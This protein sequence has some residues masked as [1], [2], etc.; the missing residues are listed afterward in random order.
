MKNKNSMFYWWPKVKNLPIPQPRTVM[1]RFKGDFTL[2]ILDG[3]L[4]PSW[5]RFFTK[6]K[7]ESKVIGYPLF[8]RSDETS[9]KHDWKNS[10]FVESEEKL[11]PNLCSILEMIAMS[12]GLSFTGVALREFLWLNARFTSHWGEMPVASERRYFVRD[13]KVECHHPYWPPSAIHKPSDK[14]WQV[15]LKELQ[16][17]TPKEVAILTRYAELVGNALGGYWSVDFCQHEYG[18]WYLTDI[19]LG[20]DSY[21][22]ATCP[23][24]DKRMLEHY[25]DPEKIEEIEEFIPFLK[26]LQ[27]IKEDKP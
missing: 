19:A 7:T 16:T 23:F 20:D 3:V 14:N 12:F 5:E 26:Q 22:W 25:G 21:H 24:A 8:M 2:D 6:L 1:I 13:G 9:N 17:E 27:K 11:Q 15:L 18:H 4:N 10:C